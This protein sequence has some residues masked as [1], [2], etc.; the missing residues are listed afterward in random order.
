MAAIRKPVGQPKRVRP[1]ALDV[2]PRSIQLWLSYSEME[3]K[4]HNVQHARNLFDAVVQERL[5]RGAAAERARCAPGLGALDAV[6]AGRQGVAGVHQAR[7]ALRRA[8]SREHNLR[9][10]GRRAPRAARV[11]HK[12]E[13]ERSRLDKARE[14]FQT[15]LEFYGG[16]QELIQNGVWCH[17][18]METR[19]K[20]YERTR[21]FYKFALERI[22]RSKSAQLYAAYTKLEKQHGTRSTLDNTVLGNMTGAITTPGSTTRLGEG[23]W[24]DLKDEGVTV[25]EEA[26][27]AGRIREV[28]ECAVLQ[29]PPSGEKRHWRR[30]IFLWLDYVLFEEIETKVGAL[31]YA[32]ACQIYQTALMLVPYKQFTFA[33]L[34]LMFAKFEIWRLDLTVACKVLGTAIGMCHKEV[35]FKGYIELEVELRE[36]DRAWTLHGK[37]LEVD[38]QFPVCHL[39]TYPPPFDPANSPTWIKCAELEGQLQDC[40]RMHRIFELGVAQ[41]PLHPPPK[42]V[43]AKRATRRDHAPS[44][45]CKR[46]L[47]PAVTNLG[48]DHQE[49][50]LVWG[51]QVQDLLVLVVFLGMMCA[52]SDLRDCRARNLVPGV[53]ACTDEGEAGLN[54]AVE[55]F[56]RERTF[57]GS[58]VGW[59]EV[60]WIVGEGY[61]TRQHKNGDGLDIGNGKRDKMA[62]TLGRAAARDAVAIA[63][64]DDFVGEWAPEGR[65]VAR[66]RCRGG[67]IDSVDNGNIRCFVVPAPRRGMSRQGFRHDRTHE[68]RPEKVV[69]PYAR[70][71]TVE[72]SV[73]VTV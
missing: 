18:K 24:Q 57:L 5:P 41:S 55:G 47:V 31:D 32:R 72:T 54:G 68:K 8:R 50:K 20:E 2:D 1:H 28:Y 6:G 13:E 52:P 21:M 53:L 27:A 30:Y 43:G 11:G 39:L 70:R 22:P 10:L 42:N 7:G 38:L 23:V 37:Y 73:P 49:D 56:A 45:L 59:N 67:G 29:V 14:V 40:A 9:A 3:L 16:D 4:S 60:I 44:D 51:K 17:C 34:W 15:T 71:D 12:F 46:I 61:R 48:E 64:G 58:K 35:W 69:R 66:R 36:F 25:E 65:K 26:A 19:L 63:I 33:K 62:M